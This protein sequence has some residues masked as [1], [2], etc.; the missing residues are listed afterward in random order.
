[1]EAGGDRLG[2]TQAELS[3][4]ACESQAVRRACQREH[5]GGQG[6]GKLRGKEKDV[7]WGGP[8]G[9]PRAWG[10]RRRAS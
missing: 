4:R 8:A 5:R 2:V 1:M 9:R 10:S 7:F 6:A 3:L